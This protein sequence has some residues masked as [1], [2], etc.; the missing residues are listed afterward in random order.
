[1]TTRLRISVVVYS[2]IVV[3]LI[4]IAIMYISRK[5]RTT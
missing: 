5:V 3:N 4:A 2:N 1:M